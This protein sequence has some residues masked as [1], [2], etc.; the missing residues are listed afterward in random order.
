VLYLN[1]LPA[2][3]LETV[4]W[5]YSDSLKSVWIFFIP[6]AGIAFLVSLMMRNYSL[7]K[8]LNSKQMFDETRQPQQ[9]SHA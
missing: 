7:D 6:L 1:K 3:V 2:D 4:K 5:L 9:E 8:V